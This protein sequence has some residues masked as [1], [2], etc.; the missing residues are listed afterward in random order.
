MHLRSHK[1]KNAMHFSRR[2][3]FATGD[4]VSQQYQGRRLLQRRLC[5]CVK[6]EKL[7]GLTAVRV[8]HSGFVDILHVIVRDV[9]ESSRDYDRR[10]ADEFL[11]Q[12]PEANPVAVFMLGDDLCRH[13]GQKDR[14]L[15]ALG[16]MVDYVCAPEQ[17]HRRLHRIDSP[18]D[19]GHLERIR[20]EHMNA[21]DGDGELRFH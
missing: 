9:G 11:R 3:S 19:V 7:F 2:R 10:G 12:I 17:E 21:V 18:P 13:R 14:F 20:F 15:H 6:I 16:G 4:A 5:L 1:I 8:G